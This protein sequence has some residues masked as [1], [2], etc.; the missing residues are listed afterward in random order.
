MTKFMGRVLNVHC[1]HD[2]LMMG[3]DG[4]QYAFFMAESRARCPPRWF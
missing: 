3:T 4:K 2:G 1:I